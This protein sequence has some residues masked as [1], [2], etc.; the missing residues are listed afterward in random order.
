MSI[1]MAIIGV[2]GMAGW[3]Y[4]NVK[5]H[6]KGLEIVG[7]YDIREEAKAR[8]AGEWGLRSYESP[9]ELYADKTV[10]LV[11]IATPND[12]HKDY[13]IACLN[14]GKHVLCEKPVT[15]DAQELEEVI[16]VAE[17]TGKLFTVNQ[18]R[19]W[20]KD[21][22]TVRKIVADNTLGKVYNIESRVQ[23]SR[24]LFGWRAFKPNG[25]GLLLDWGVHL[26]DQV[27]DLIN[28]KVVSVQA[29]IHYVHHREVD[30]CFTVLL[31]FEGGCTVNISI[32]TNCYIDL[33]RWHVSGTDG[34]A[35]ILD[36]EQNGHIVKLAD[37]SIQDWEDAIVYTH[38]GPTHT[39][40]PRPKY[41]TKKEELP[42]VKGDWVDLYRNIVGVLDGKAE[43]IVKPEQ[44]LRVMKVID[45][46]F[47]SGRTGQAITTGI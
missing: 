30:D 23:G 42:T 43:L 25:G 22:L 36:W 4:K 34:T 40:L 15:L 20:D 41:T 21:Y 13:A 46:A 31:R 6:V 24:R 17:K 26:L 18:N 16:A 45:A 3:H 2:G 27:M 38:A 44:A 14:A 35:V 47:E 8:I 9:E 19:R 12:V 5:G 39:M 7:G 10:D 28:E 29:H 37:P 1:K 11:L 32:T 33:P